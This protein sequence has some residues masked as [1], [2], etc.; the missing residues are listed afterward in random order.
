MTAEQLA[1]AYGW[2]QDFRAPLQDWGE[3]LQMVDITEQWVRNQGLS[4]GS[5]QA[6][7]PQVPL[8]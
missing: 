7:A 6:L 4:L 3:L 1:T 8:Q 5:A 2:L